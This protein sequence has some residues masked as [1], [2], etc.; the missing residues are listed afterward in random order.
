MLV[1]RGVHVVRLESAE[2]NVVDKMIRAGEEG[3]HV[4][5]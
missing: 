4:G 5:T 3:H 2:K 1:G